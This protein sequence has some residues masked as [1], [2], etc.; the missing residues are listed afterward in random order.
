M[1]VLWGSQEDNMTTSAAEFLSGSLCYAAD[2][3]SLSVTKQDDSY[4]VHDAVQC[5]VQL[6]F[7]CVMF[8]H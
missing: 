4:N 1:E 5:A 7:F 2:N 3:H 8:H 6:R